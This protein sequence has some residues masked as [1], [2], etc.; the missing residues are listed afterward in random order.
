MK[1]LMV[2]TD[3]DKSTRFLFIKTKGIKNFFFFYKN[4]VM[5]FDET[6]VCTKNPLKPNS[7]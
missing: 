3:W 6:S 5:L 4:K 7:T 2:L 1:W